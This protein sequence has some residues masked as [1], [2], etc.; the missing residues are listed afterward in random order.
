MARSS[1]IV[2]LAAL[3]PAALASSVA[4]KPLKSERIDHERQYRA[5]LTLA[6]RAPAE[7]MEAAAVWGEKGG[8]R[9][10]RHCRAVALTVAE[11]YPE[12]A[13]LLDR[14]ARE[15]DDGEATLKA[16]LHG[17]AAN[18]WLL[19]GAPARALTAVTAGLRLAPGSAELLV[20]RARI[21]AEQKHYGAALADLDAAL[22]LRQRAATHAF[23]A[24][25]LRHLGRVVEALAAAQQALAL[26][27]RD[28]SARLEKAL[29][30]RDGGRAGEA[31]AEL[32]KL[33]VDHEG[34]AAADSALAI[35]KNM[36]VGKDGG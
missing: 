35:L 13:A 18:A 27:P 24:G 7:A 33:A 26:D 29:A 9:P 23:R 15:L 11:R 21:R 2:L 5:C 3:L 34:T 1:S 20:D 17:Q 6:Q 32:E 4:A 25:A 12:A 31:R 30:L 14:L 8:G 22:K 19:A 16:G 28:P 36:P 10:A